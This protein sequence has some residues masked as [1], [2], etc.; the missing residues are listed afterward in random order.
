MLAHV[1]SCFCLFF[2]FLSF[3]F[4][5]KFSCSYVPPFFVVVSSC[6]EKS[7]R[8]F[9]LTITEGSTQSTITVE[10]LISMIHMHRG[11]WHWPSRKT[12]R[13]WRLYIDESG[14]IYWHILCVC[15]CV[16]WSFL[17]RGVQVPMPG[18]W[19]TAE[20]R[21][22]TLSGNLKLPHNL[23]LTGESPC[24]INTVSYHRR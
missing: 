16:C 21:A 4:S 7:L 10:S 20:P 15:T 14:L 12:P 13:W 11:R 23:G 9:W 2:F 6:V 22:E 8:T 17:E 19:R 24:L 5:S 1:V 3:F 18:Q